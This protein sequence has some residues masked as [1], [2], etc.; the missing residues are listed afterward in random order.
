MP[1]AGKERKSTVLCQRPVAN[2]KVSVDEGGAVILHY[3][4]LSFVAIPYV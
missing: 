2:V 1:R 3:H 4:L